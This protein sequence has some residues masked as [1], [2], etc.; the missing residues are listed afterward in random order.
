[1][2]D[3]IGSVDDLGDQQ[4]IFDRAM[5]PF[6]AGMVLYGGQ[7][8]GATGRQVID[9]DHV[10]ATLQKG[11]G[12]MGTD[13]TGASG[14]Q[15]GGHAALIQNRRVEVEVGKSNRLGK[16]WQVAGLTTIKLAHKYGREFRRETFP[17]LGV[18]DRLTYAR[19]DVRVEIFK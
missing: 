2:V 13:K 11:F 9:D 12:E 17:V 3:A 15:A 8:V 4:R 6:E 7:V 14:D 10:V 16:P 19:P 5:D 18:T 1:M